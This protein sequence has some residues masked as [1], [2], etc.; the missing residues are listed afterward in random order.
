M[1]K[2]K[3]WY[4]YTSESYLKTIIK[5]QLESVKFLV[6]KGT[7]S[8]FNKEVNILR[9]MVRAYKLK[10]LGR[11]PSG[12]EVARKKPSYKHLLKDPGVRSTE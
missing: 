6:E 2:K 8:E 9:G 7:W 5:M 11:S 12:Q 4:Y 10:L 1:P 3:R